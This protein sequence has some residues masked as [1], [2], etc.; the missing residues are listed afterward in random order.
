LAKVEKVHVIG[1][2]DDGLAG[3]SPAVRQIVEAADLL[4]GQDVLLK[5]IPKSRAERLEL[6]NDLDGV[7]DRIRKLESAKIAVLSIGDP[8]FYG[9]ARYL[10][11]R[12]GKERFEVLP[13]VSSMQLA[14]ARV[15]ESWDEAVLTNLASQPLERVVEKIRSAEKVGAFT[16][17]AISPAVLAKA[18]LDAQIDYFTAYVCENLGSRDERVTQGELTEIAAM[19]FSPLNVVILVRK[20]DV[21]DRP[22]QSAGKRLFGNPDAVFLQSQPKHGLLTP[23]EIRSI[24]LAELDLGPRSVVWDVGAG[25]GSVAIE[26]AQIARDGAVYAI[27]MDPED[28]ALIRSNAEQFAVRNLAPVL[29]MAPA[30]WKDLPDPDAIFIGG[31]GRKVHDIV[32]AAM[33]RLKPGGRIVAAMGSIENVA[34]VHEALHSATG[35]AKVWLLQFSRGNSQLGS[36]RFDSINPTF[37]ISAVKPR[38]ESPDYD[39]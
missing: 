31:T 1:M 25:S 3:L 6:G 29:G 34:D 2:G 19:E 7:V 15:K 22:M 18:L 37:L 11:D 13:H 27:E 4:I 36:L 8:L 26:C 28:H 21:P 17:D 24:A 32:A 12:I 23:S 33:L 30:V 5:C 39:V 14:F 35:D 38:R 10:C 9:T 20:P 16:T